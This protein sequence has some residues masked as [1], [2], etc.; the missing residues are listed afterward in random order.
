MGYREWGLLDAERETM[1]DLPRSAV[2]AGGAGGGAGRELAAAEKA[3]ASLLTGIKNYAVFPPGHAS[4]AT[5]LQGVRQAVARFSEEFGE[6]GFEVAPRQILYAGQPVYGGEAGADNPASVLYRDGIRWL[7]F[8]AGVE[9]A[10]LA[11]LFQL[12]NHYR[13]VAD[14]PEDDLVTA[15]WRADLPHIYHEASYELWDTETRSDLEQYQVK[16]P[17]AVTGKPGSVNPAADSGQWERLRPGCADYQPVSLVVSQEERG[18]WDLTP[19]E[20]QYL[21]RQIEEDHQYDSSEAA[22]SLMLLVL[23]SEDEARVYASILT[24]LREEF[25]A[26][27]LGRDFQ[28]AYRII[29]QVRRTGALLALE[30]PWTVPLHNHFQDEITRPAALQPLVPLW[31]VLSSLYGAEIKNFV[32]LLQHLPTKAGLTL[33]GMLGQVNLAHARGLITEIIASFATRDRQV[34]EIL[35]A[36]NDE[37]LALRMLR[38]VRDLP[39]Q[40]EARRLLDR[41]MNVSSQRVRV[42]AGRMLGWQ[43]LY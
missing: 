41:V 33:A 15:L 21:A 38:V 5:L 19:E 35:L 27:L 4:T 6:L 43:N 42:E 7:T 2:G 31:P 28:R 20:Q 18:H 23:R 10:E 11:V 29:D 17:G 12:C 8:A 3:I 1:G 26:A 36:G 9:V 24:Y 25:R 34:L 30:K 39:D 32:A 37:E 14:E 22:I 16:P 40:E 13:V